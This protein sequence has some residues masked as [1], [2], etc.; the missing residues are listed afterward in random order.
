MLA[1]GA[2]G[3]E[4]LHLDLLGA[5]LDLTVILDLRHDLQG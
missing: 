3:A 4:H 2:A 1:A 5:D